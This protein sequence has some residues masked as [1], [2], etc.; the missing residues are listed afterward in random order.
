MPRA[1]SFLQS[2]LQRP[3]FAHLGWS[4]LMRESMTA[5][6]RAL[7]RANAQTSVGLLHGHAPMRGACAVRPGADA[8]IACARRPGAARRRGTFLIP[9]CEAS[10]G[11]GRACIGFDY[12][13][14]RAPLAFRRGLARARY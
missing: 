4:S 13:T 14:F 5:T 6:G 2:V 11:T 9:G 1:L 3:S 7:R 12:R 8:I 10:G